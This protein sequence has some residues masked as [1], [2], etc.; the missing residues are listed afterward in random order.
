LRAKSGSYRGSVGASYRPQLRLGLI[1]HGH[2]TG[3][4]SSRT[5]ERATCDPVAFRFIA[6]SE[7][8]DH[9]TIPAFRWR[10]LKQ[11]ESLFVPVLSVAREMGLLKLGT[12]ALDGMSIPVELARRE[13]R[14][15]AIARAQATIEARAKQRHAYEQAEHDASGGR[16]IRAVPPPP[17]QNPTPLEAMVHCL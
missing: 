7:H 6:A 3:V 1:I 10:F 13:K 8:P 5:P 12:V 15:A 11:I 4:S 17:Q 9:D 14:P 16:R 2:A